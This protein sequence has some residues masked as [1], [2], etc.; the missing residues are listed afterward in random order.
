MASYLDLQ[1]PAER[2]KLLQA[3]GDVQF[4]A[5]LRHTIDSYKDVTLT[6]TQMDTLNA[7][8]V[9]LIAAQGANKVI[10]VEAVFAFN[11][12]NSVAFE[13]GTGTVDVRYQNSSG[14]LAAQLTNA[15]VESGADAYF[16]AP[17]L[18]CVA[19]ANQPVVA[20]ASADVTAGNGTLYLRVFYRVVDASTL[21]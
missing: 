7:T 6:A 14:G 2:Q 19:L 9:T 3:V 12:F 4:N 18:A 15:F 16:A 17:G 5:R 21:A 13:L 8:P 10:I 1:A 11:D 20:Y